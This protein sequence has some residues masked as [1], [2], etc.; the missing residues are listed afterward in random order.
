MG[1]GRDAVETTEKIPNDAGSNELP[2]VLD[3][4]A[5]QNVAVGEDHELS[6]DRPAQRLEL[7]PQSL[8]LPGAQDPARPPRQERDARGLDLLDVDLKF[9][10]LKLLL[11]L[12]LV[13]VLEFFDNG[14]QNVNKLVRTSGHLNVGTGSEQ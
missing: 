13:D 3:R 2:L 10:T 14:S 5:Q 11:N 12:I 1:G 6:L 4:A 8:Q 7:R 9:P